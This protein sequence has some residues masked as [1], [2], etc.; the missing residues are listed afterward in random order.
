MY[1]EKNISLYFLSVF[2][3]LK[4]KKV[5][6]FCTSEIYNCLFVLFFLDKY[7]IFKDVIEV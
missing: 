3:S 5:V 1:D 7:D 6:Y 2:V 4:Q